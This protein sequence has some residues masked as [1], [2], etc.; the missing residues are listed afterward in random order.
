MAKGRQYA[1]ATE[2]IDKVI[3]LGQFR[4]ESVHRAVGSS[5]TYL[6][7]RRISGVACSDT[8]S[9][10]RRLISVLAEAEHAAAKLDVIPQRTETANA[11]AEQWAEIVG[12]MAQLRLL[13]DL[14]QRTY[15]APEERIVGAA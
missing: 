14:D 1:A 11:R 2:A 3:N 12:L 10:E 9:P 13:L 4:S 15:I 5:L 8:D 7:A 6:G